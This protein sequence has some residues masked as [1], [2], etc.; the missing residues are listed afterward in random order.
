MCLD[1]SRINQSQLSIS[2]IDN[3]EVQIFKMFEEANIN[4]YHW[5]KKYIYIGF[6][7]LSI[8][9]YWSMLSSRRLLLTDNASQAYSSFASYLDL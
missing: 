6:H 2:L 9:R 5:K 7:I 8:S 1:A 3:P 4:Q